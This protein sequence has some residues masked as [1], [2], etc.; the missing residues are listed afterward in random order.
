MWK[1]LYDAQT[2]SSVVLLQTEPDEHILPIW[3]GQAEALSIAAG[4]EKV[5]LGRPMTHDL[6]KTIVETAQMTVA[7][8]RIHTLKDSTFFASIRLTTPEGERID[9][10]ARSSDAIALALRCDA[11]IFAA[12]QVLSEVLRDNMDIQSDI[13]NL[14]E[15]FL[16]NLPDELFGKYKM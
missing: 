4:A 8:A 13:E 3:V 6:L 9:I 1:V 5:S 7:W 11:P 16:A 12:D 10:D 15:D 14:S 2:G